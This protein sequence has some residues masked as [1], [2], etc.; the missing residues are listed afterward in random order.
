MRKIVLTYGLIAGGMLGAMMLITIPFQ[1]QIGFD[2]G[3]IVGYTTMVVA[4]LMIY[5]GVKSYR[6]NETGGRITFGRACKVGGLIMLVATV[7]YVA[8]WQVVYYKISPDFMEKYSAYAAEK[9]R[10]SGAS[11]AEIAAQLAEQEK[12]AEMYKNPLVNIGFTFLEP[13]PVGV[14]FTLVTAGVLSRKRKEGVA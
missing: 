9:A 4:F 7:C 8:T 10:A 5:V 12:F 6:D 14:V 11:A 13:L 3:M 2:N 1:E